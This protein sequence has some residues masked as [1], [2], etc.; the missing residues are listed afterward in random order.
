MMCIRGHADSPS[1]GPPSKLCATLGF[2]R[3][4]RMDRTIAPSIFPLRSQHSV[5][6]VL[7]A[8]SYVDTFMNVI[9]W[10]TIDQLFSK[11]ADEAGRKP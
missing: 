1:D 2:S 6:S 3:R 10:Q 9:R 4:L 8:V 11:L 7:R 5:N